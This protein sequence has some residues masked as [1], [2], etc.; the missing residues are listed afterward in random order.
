MV[1]IYSYYNPNNKTFYFKKCITYSQFDD[2]EK[3]EYGHI[4]IQK[5]VVLEDNIYDLDQFLELK[6]IKKLHV[7][8]QQKLKRYRKYK[9]KE[10]IKKLINH[11]IDLLYRFKSRF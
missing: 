9:R 7:Q 6:K 3:N 5:I 10:F 4:I 11:I 8:E 2:R 1:L